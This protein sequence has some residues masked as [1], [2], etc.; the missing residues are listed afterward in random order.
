MW[1]SQEKS[2][3]IPPDFSPPWGKPCKGPDELRQ[4]GP[5]AASSGVGAVKGSRT[6]AVG[7]KGSAQRLNSLTYL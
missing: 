1:R 2:L 3:Q 6:W 7:W 4:A 5:L